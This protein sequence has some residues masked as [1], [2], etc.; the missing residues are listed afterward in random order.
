M[1]R[2]VTSL[3]RRR[4]Q[5]E[6]KRRFILYCE[7]SNT[8]RHYFDTIKRSFQN[9]LIEVEINSGVGV[10]RTVAEKAIGKAK[11]LLRGRRRE[12]NSFE[13]KDK[14]WAI[15]DRD[16]HPHY[17]DAIARCNANGVNVARSNPCFELW[18]ILH[19]ENFDKPDDHMQVQQH[20]HGLRPLY[21]PHCGKMLDCSELMGEVEIAEA[22]A[23]RQLTN[24][25]KEGA[26]YGRPST[27]VYKLTRA[28]REAAE[29][30]S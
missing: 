26:S 20:L 17:D 2:K 8:E 27:T 3:S 21:D 22:R 9:A 23:I 18:L 28:I 10:P 12:R 1:A 16:T 19:I 25:Q 24:R 5:R 15:F 14:I 4:A 13:E 6:P 11:E 30:S 7:G 29:E